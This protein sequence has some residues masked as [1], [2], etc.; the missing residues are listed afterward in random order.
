MPDAGII[1]KSL[2]IILINFKVVQ[3]LRTYLA[4]HI[5]CGQQGY[6]FAIMT[7]K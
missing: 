4:L 6:F 2:F 7:L 3:R 5:Q 1:V